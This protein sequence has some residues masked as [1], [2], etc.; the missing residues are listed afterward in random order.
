MNG[1]L[2]FVP[3]YQV[4]I[5]GEP[6]PSALRSSISSVVYD[7]GIDAADRVEIGIANANLHWLQDHI[8]GLGFRPPTGISVGPIKGP[9]FTGTGLFDMANKLELSLG[10]TDSALKHVFKGEVT[11][12]DV[13]F[14]AGGMPTMTLVAH[15]YLNRLAQGSYGRGFGPLPDWIIAAILSGENLLLPLIDPSVG[16]A[17][18]ALAVVNTI[19]NGS[20]RKQKGQTDLQLLQEIAKT[21]DADFWVEGDILYLSRFLKQYSPS[22]TLKWGESLLEFSPH[23][24]TIGQVVGVGAKFTLREIPLSLMVTVSWD[25]DRESLMVTVVPGAAAAEMKTL[26]GPIISFINRPIGS[27]A[28]ITNSALFLARKLRNTINN[29]LTGSGS[30]VGN[31]AIR[32][33]AMI[34]LDGLGTDFSGVYRVA[35][36]TH[37]IDSNGYRTNFKVKK[38]IIP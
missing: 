37:T 13:N 10:Y 35:S 34:Q 25:F 19:F 24:T 28:D 6:I 20:G 17:S 12:V 27:P 9:S 23:V 15:D 26:I 38:E 14:P 31:P 21:Y 33:G 2:Q 8:K 22:V 30:A 5:N 16:A 29:R 3:D 1:S 4:K 32:A 7:D 11:G 36:A 18:T